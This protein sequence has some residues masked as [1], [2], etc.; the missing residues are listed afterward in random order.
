MSGLSNRPY[1]LSEQDYTTMTTVIKTLRL[2]EYLADEHNPQM[3]S[4][5]CE[6]VSSALG[7]LASQLDQVI[8]S[9]DGDTIRQVNAAL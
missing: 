2:F 7:L 4:I 5:E 1:T 3:G 9:I 6:L 8:S